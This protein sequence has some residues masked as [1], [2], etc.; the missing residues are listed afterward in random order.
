VKIYG[1]DIFWGQNLVRRGEKQLEESLFY[2][3]I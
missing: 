1:G 3:E 2:I